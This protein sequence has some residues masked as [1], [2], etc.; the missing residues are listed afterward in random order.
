[1]IGRLDLDDGREGQVLSE[2]PGSP[3]EFLPDRLAPAKAQFQDVEDSLLGEELFKIIAAC[4]V[5]EYRCS[6]SRM[7]SI[8][9]GSWSI[10]SSATENDVSRVSNAKMISA[11]L[12]LFTWE[13]IRLGISFSFDLRRGDFSD[14]PM[15][16]ES[17][18]ENPDAVIFS[19]RIR[20]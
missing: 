1:L 11:P 13:S 14:H 8:S 3:D 6:R 7:A 17:I 10:S 16:I 15:P 4:V 5:Y 9:E 12:P 18:E 19:D 20:R 2:S